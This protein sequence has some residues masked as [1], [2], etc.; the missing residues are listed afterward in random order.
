MNPATRLLA[1][2]LTIH[3]HTLRNRVIMGSMHTGFEE[4]P[5]GA[6]HLAAFYAERAKGGVALIIT[7]GIAPNAD[8]AVVEEGAKLTDETEVAW[9]RTVTEATHEH[10]AKICL[11]I[12][13]TGR[14]AM[15]RVPV[16][17]SAIQAPINPARPRALSTDEV[18]QTVQ[19]YIRCAQLAQQAGYDGVEVMGSEGYLINQFIAPATNQR[20]D[21]Y[22]GSLANRHRFALE[23]V[24][25]I[26][27]ACGASFIII[28]RISLL[29]LIEN[30]ST[31]PENQQLAEALQQ[32]GVSM[33]NTGI[34]WHE[35][36]IPT[37]ATMVPRAAFAEFTGKLKA[38]S[39]VPVI[40]T[41]R[42]N[43]PEVAE[44]ILGDGLADMV[45]LAR[46]FLA[47]ADWVNKAVAGE[48]KR[49]NTCIACNQACLDHIF[50][51]KLTSCL[52][53][54]FAC[55]ET[56]LIFQA[57]TQ[58]KNIAVVGA[59][60]AGMA[61]A[62]TAAERGHHVTVFDAQNQIGGQ[63]NIAK[64]IPGKPEFYET[65]RYFEQELAAL[66]VRLQLG[67]TVTAA[68]LAGFDEIVLAS[69]IVPRQLAIPGIDHPKVLSYLDVLRERKPVGHSVAIIGA[70]GIGF[71][72]AEF[73]SHS[74]QDSAESPELFQQEWQID[75]SL[76]QAGALASPIPKL[77]ASARQIWLLQRKDGM[78]GRNL[79]KT[80]GWI[81]RLTLK[82]KGV[83]MLGGVQYERI[84]DAGLHIRIGE[85]TQ[86]L[87]VDNVI[88]CAG[89]EPNRS[90]LADCQALGKPVHVI[91]GADV[92]TE[93]D[94]KRAIAAGTKLALAL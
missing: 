6:P 4:H 30:G 60:P 80:T 40:A 69:G 42:I 28:F 67:R 36:R 9:H 37:I 68:D 87:P 54:P 55:H 14:Y 78:V 16:A 70:G 8:G 79:G 3:N 17:P 12:L 38:I 51:G 76:M 57:A 56:Q 7:G 39:K 94:A 33:F 64:T 49:I 31:W 62:K 43:M 24:E 53:N 34:G 5:E 88:I 71:D 11:Q 22:G 1:Q 52:V 77:P 46:P 86:V 41:N 25:G 27:Q 83:N 35:A 20:D 93:L 63:L 66:N 65:L 75:P 59:G 61:F 89:Q 81:H 23:I 47:D 2:P 73:L 21:E 26:R 13:H 85:A 82:Y 45:C 90:L 15:S 44:Q 84:D 32:A 29:D 72:V 18:K 92:A 91:G 10:G 48:D 19:D 58:H 50:A 74:G